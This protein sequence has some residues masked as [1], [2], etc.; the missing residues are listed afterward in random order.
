MISLSQIGL[1]LFISS[2]IGAIPAL[3]V[4]ALTSKIR[5]TIEGF[6]A[7]AMLAASWLS[8][9]VP[10]INK[11]HGFYGQLEVVFALIVGYLSLQAFHAVLPHG[12]EGKGDEG[13]KQTRD[14][15][16]RAW[17][18]G[19]AIG[20][21]NIPEGFAVGIGATQGGVEAK[22]LLYTIGLQNLPEGFIVATSLL[23]TGTKVRWVF[24]ITALTGIIEVLGATLGW[25]SLQFFKDT[26][27]LGLAFAAGAMLFVVC[28]EMIPECQKENESQGTLGLIIGISTVLLVQAVL[29]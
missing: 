18:I 25:F 8:L 19:L 14:K 9:L 3:V 10:A 28:R 15:L 21:H 2:A 26:L 17:L 23:M 6:C 29:E 1:T 7:G 12:H 4:Y 5:A 13:P 11:S 20:L 22:I 24:F 16:S 27:P